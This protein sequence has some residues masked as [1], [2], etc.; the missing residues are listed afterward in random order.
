LRV[1]QLDASVVLR[2]DLAGSPE[3]LTILAG[4]EASV[5]RLDLLRAAVGDDPADW[6]PPLTGRVWP[7]HSD[8]DA[9]GELPL[10][11]AAE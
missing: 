6:F 2:L 11:Q 1:R 5:R 4:R 9:G 8:N 10:W 3:V 7:E